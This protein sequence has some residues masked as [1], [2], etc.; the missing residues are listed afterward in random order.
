MTLV[1]EQLIYTN[2]NEMILESTGIL[3]C[4]QALFAFS[5]RQLL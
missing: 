2:N 1:Y 5:F 4:N 3:T